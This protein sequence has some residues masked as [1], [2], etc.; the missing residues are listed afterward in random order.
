VTEIDEATIAVGLPKSG[1]S[2]VMRKE[3]IE[4]LRTYPTGLV[5]AH[6]CNS[7]LEPDVTKSYDD[8]KQWRE[9]YARAAA[10]KKP[11]PRGASFRCSSEEVGDLVMEL[12]RKFNSAKNVKLPIKFPLDEFSLSDTSLPTY[13]GKQDRQLWSLRRHLGVAPFIN[14]Q[15]VTD[16]V[17][18]FWRQATKVYIFCQT[19]EQARELEKTLS[20]QK[21]ALD[22]VINA[23]KYRYLLWRQGEGLV[24]A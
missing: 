21:H 7:E 22:A 15:L 8:T 2:T 11:F 24:S 16:V 6:D 23:P 4:F 5:L 18:K 12:G 20:L 17:V 13:Q 10:E 9:A 1:K 14:A 3:C 19:E